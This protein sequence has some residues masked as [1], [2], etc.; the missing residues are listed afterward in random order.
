MLLLKDLWAQDLPVGGEVSVG[1]GQLQ[2][3]C[4]TIVDRQMVASD[5][6]SEAAQKRVDLVR[7][8]VSK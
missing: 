3:V 5:G 8:K 7:N 1:R 4:A 2:G 6:K